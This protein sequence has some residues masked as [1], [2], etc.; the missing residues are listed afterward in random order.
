MSE[1]TRVDNE[2]MIWEGAELL[3]E[4]LVPIDEI[5]PFEGNPR[6]GAVE[7]LMA[8]LGRWGQIRAVLTDPNGTIIAGHH[9]TEAARQLGWTHV[10]VIPHVFKSD[11]EARA[12]LIADNALQELGITVHKDQMAL[13][14][15]D[16]DLTGTG[17]DQDDLKDRDAIERRKTRWVSYTELQMHP[18]NN[19]HHPQEQIEHMVQ[20]LREQ[21]FYRNLVCARDGTILAGHGLWT[22]AR[23]MGVQKL[24]VTFLECAPEDP[25]ALKVLIADNHLQH[26]AEDDD[27]NLAEQLREL[28]EGDADSL[29]GTG[30]DSMMLAN[31]VMTTRPKSE[32]ED[33]DHAAE[34]VGMAD[35][36]TP[37]KAIQL[38]VSF[39]TEEQ[40]VE[41]VEKHGDV[42][43]HVRGDVRTWSALW[44]AR[45]RQDLASVYFDIDENQTKL[46]V[47]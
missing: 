12:Y 28:Q 27:R 37:G 36:E 31:L 25:V 26:M 40:R 24:P 30:Y 35:F 15:D 14:G 47:E 11:E 2:D 8:S 13:L 3:Q 39:E 19:R 18:R 5:R 42:E 38:V 23:R 34:W 29:V 16:A 17:I 10:A 1:S 22:A 7:D 21:G 4:H 43:P 9:V 41:F 32:I 44:P 46:E 45:E 20:S 33:H 6:R